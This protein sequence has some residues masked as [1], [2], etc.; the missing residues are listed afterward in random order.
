MGEVDS[1]LNARGRQLPG[2]LINNAH[3]GPGKP[4]SPGWYRNHYNLMI[5][6]SYP[7]IDP[8][9]IIT[10]VCFHSSGRCTANFIFAGQ[11][12]GSSRPHFTAI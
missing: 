12:L 10:L 3:R 6:L 2:S 1:D 11:N 5:F 4:V 9:V 8:T 7:K